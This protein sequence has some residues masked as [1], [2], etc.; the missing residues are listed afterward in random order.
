MTPSI[1]LP[2]TPCFNLLR[3]FPNLSLLFAFV[4]ATDLEKKRIEE[5]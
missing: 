1:D 2:S 3:P 5:S 4:S